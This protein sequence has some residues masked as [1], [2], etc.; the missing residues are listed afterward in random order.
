LH[1]VSLRNL[2]SHGLLNLHRQ[3]N[4]HGAVVL[5]A[6]LTTNWQVKDLP[7]RL[8]PRR[9][10]APTCALQHKLQSTTGSDIYALG[11]E[12]SSPVSIGGPPDAYI[13]QLVFTEH[14]SALRER[15]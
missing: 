9:S 11:S 6:P 1:S 3:S 15:T 12:L 13:A 8:G 7:R 14:P 5:W 10:N 2:R 4:P